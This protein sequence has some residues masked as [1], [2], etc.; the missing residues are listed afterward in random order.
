MAITWTDIR[1]NI[2]RTTNKDGYIFVSLFLFIV[3]GSTVIYDLVQTSAVERTDLTTQSFTMALLLVHS[4]A[5]YYGL[6]GFVYTTQAAEG[7]SKMA[8]LALATII[9]HFTLFFTR[10]GFEMYRRHYRKEQY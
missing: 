10:V 2:K 6:L 5:F 3:L 9:G 7:T 1:E 8:K 4:L